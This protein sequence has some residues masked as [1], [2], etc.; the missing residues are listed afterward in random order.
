MNIELDV[1]EVRLCL[2]V[3]P[4]TNN[5]YRSVAGKGVLISKRGRE[6]RTEVAKACSEY[7]GTFVDSDRLSV[8]VVLRPPDKRKR[9]LD[10]FCGKALLD[11]LMKAG[12]FVDDSQIDCLTMIRGKLDRGNSGVDVIIRRI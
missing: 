8:L 11:S 9:D 4:S 2:G 12:V 6:Y 1:D 3:P 5:Y 7:V 10:N